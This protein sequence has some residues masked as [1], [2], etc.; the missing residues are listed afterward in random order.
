VTNKKKQ[1]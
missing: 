1:I